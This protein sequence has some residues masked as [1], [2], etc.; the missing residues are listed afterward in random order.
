[1]RP[2]KIVETLAAITDEEFSSNTDKA[3][4]DHLMWQVEQ[5]GR[6]QATLNKARSHQHTSINLNCLLKNSE[7]YVEALKREVTVENDS[8]QKVEQDTARL[9]HL[10]E[11][12]G[13]KYF[14]PAE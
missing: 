7:A 9:T 1:M 5:K 3:F 12:P 13:R 2:P 11:Q 4:F 8:R 6:L 10:N 14:F